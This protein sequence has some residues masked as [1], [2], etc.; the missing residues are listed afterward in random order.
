MIEAIYTAVG[1]L[2]GGFSVWW[3]MRFNQGPPGLEHVRV[4]MS[5]VVNDEEL[6]E[7]R[8]IRRVEMVRAGRKTTRAD[9][10][11][12]AKQ[13]KMRVRRGPRRVGR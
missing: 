13:F 6:E 7:R 5:R 9:G 2:A 10:G 8:K 12:N 1:F 3:V 4:F 11:P